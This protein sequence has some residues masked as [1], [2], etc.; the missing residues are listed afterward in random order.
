MSLQFIADNSR[1]ALNLFRGKIYISFHI[2][3]I[4][5][6]IA[7]GRVLTSK[8]VYN[9]LYLI[10]VFT[11]YWYS[12]DINK[13]TTILGGGW[14]SLYINE[15]VLECNTHCLSSAE[16]TGGISEGPSFCKYVVEIPKIETAFFT[17]K[18][19]KVARIRTCAFFGF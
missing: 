4:C 17:N 15:Y 5:S 18:W 12:E 16:A 9:L 10:I 11:A 6:G 7:C 13:T 14:L 19:I 2:I 8:L 3:Q 1:F